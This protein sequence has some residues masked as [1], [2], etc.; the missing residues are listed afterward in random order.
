MNTSIETGQLTKALLAF[1][2]KVNKVVKDANNPFFK[3]KYASLSNILDTIS[4]PLLDSGLVVVQFPE[5]EHG[6]TT[7]LMHTS[8][9]W[10]ES[11]Y[12]MK[13]KSDTPQDNGSAITY[14]RRYAIGAILSLNIDEDDDGN[15]ASGR[16]ADKMSDFDK[17]RLFS[18]LGTSTLEEETREYKAAWDSI[19]ACNDWDTYQKI[20]HRLEDLQKEPA[21]PSQKDIAK[22]VSKKVSMANS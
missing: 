22:Q 21:N 6:L 20:Q 5:G 13:P 2:S 10:M 12:Y 3:S 9:E 15:K 18:M 17:A 4:G 16:K 1:H 11:T 7:R 19:K 14:Q 8:G